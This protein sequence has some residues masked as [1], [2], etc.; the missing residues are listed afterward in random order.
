[1]ALTQKYLGYAEKVEVTTPLLSFPLDSVEATIDLAAEKEERLMPSGGYRA[2]IKG[3][4]YSIKFKISDLTSIASLK[5]A[6][7]C[8]TV[9][10]TC[11]SAEGSTTDGSTGYYVATKFCVTF[12][13]ATCHLGS[14]STG[15]AGEMELTFKIAP[16]D[17]GTMTDPTIAWA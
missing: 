6:M 3:K 1:M 15:A 11:K 16:N 9:K 13:R 5:D 12:A 10:I 4:P 17:D 2:F 8:S 7:L 14:I